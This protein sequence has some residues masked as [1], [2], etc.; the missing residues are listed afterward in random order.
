MHKGHISANH[1]RRECRECDFFYISGASIPLGSD[2][3]NLSFKRWFGR[4]HLAESWRIQAH[5]R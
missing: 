4:L 2:G 3:G 5:H 1:C